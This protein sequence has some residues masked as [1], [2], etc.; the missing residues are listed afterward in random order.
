MPVDVQR[1]DAVAHVDRADHERVAGVGQRQ[2]RERVAVRVGA[3]EQ[4][5]VAVL[6][7]PVGPRLGAQVQ[8]R[9]GHRVLVDRPQRH[10]AEA[11]VD[12]AGGELRPGSLA[13]GLVWMSTIV[14]E[15]TSAPVCGIVV[16]RAPGLDDQLADEAVAPV[17]DAVDVVCQK[18][19]SSWTSG[20]QRYWT[21]SMPAYS[22]GGVLV[23]ERLGQRDRLRGACRSRRSGGSRCSRCARPAA[24]HSP[25]WN[26]VTLARLSVVVARVPRPAVICG[27][28]AWNG[29]IV[30]SYDMPVTTPSEACGVE[31]HVVD[32]DVRLG[33]AREVVRVVLQAR[34]RH[35]HA[36]ADVGADRERL[37]GLAAGEHVGDVVGEH[38]D[39]AVGVDG[40]RRASPAA[41]GRRATRC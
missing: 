37:D 38:E 29:R 1:V 9:V 23:R 13:S 36:V 18:T 20:Y 14:P 2:R 17:V 24:I 4:R 6:R 35:G 12:E 10:L 15:S 7:E 26:F 31:L 25:A 40:A 30:C 32:V 28:S 3:E 34:E 11:A 22:P 33:E 27:S 19:L 5:R 8:R 41:A 39:L 16:G 21:N